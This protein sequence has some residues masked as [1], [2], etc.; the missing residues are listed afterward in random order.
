MAKNG[1]SFLDKVLC[2]VTEESGE[3]RPLIQFKHPKEL[4]VS[5]LNIICTFKKKLYAYKHRLTVSIFLFTLCY[6]FTIKDI[7]RLIFPRFCLI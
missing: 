2:I 7:C 3:D 1:K 6:L 4:E 5:Y